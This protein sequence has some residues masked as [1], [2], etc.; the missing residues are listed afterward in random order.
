M[1]S[2]PLVA[3]AAALGFGG[4]AAYG[5][6]G[7][8]TT[9]ETIAAEP[10]PSRTIVVAGQPLPFGTVLTHDHLVEVPWG[11]E[12][13]PEGAF[14]TREELLR[15]G[16]RVVLSST[17]T[18]EP[19]VAAKISDPNGRGTL[20]VLLEEGMRAVSVRVDE[21]R[22]VSGFVTPGDR[23]D[24][25]L[26][27]ANEVEGRI[28]DVLLQNVRV[29]AIDQ[30]LDERHDK[31]TIGR[32]A[33]LELDLEGAQKVILAEGIGTLSLVL[34]QPGQTVEPARNRVTA[35]DLAPSLAPAA[36]GVAAPQQVRINVFRNGNSAAEYTVRPE[37]R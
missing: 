23:V 15:E 17:A 9:Q 30:L 32:T 12:R 1:K 7:L 35:T 22:G 25:I 27:R 3:L 16:R 31:P 10:P 36:A 4:A 19:I 2:A 13:M 20:S 24:V 37:R 33:T 8:L 14:M 5:V 34:R 18:N 29:L 21:V 11:A 28:A 6:S 26:T